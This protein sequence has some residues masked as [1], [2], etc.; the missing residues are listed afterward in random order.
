M[1][2]PE[3]VPAVAVW[4]GRR[5]NSSRKSV[6]VNV[7]NFGLASWRRARIRIVRVATSRVA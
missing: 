4:R 2:D 6:K 7:R 5:L 1:P 3:R